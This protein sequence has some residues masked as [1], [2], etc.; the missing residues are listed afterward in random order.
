LVDGPR[1]NPNDIDLREEQL[2]IVKVFDQAGGRLL[3]VGEPGSGKTVLL[4]KIAEHLEQQHRKNASAPLPIVLNLSAWQQGSSVHSWM[5]DQLCD[6]VNGLGFPDPD[7][8]SDLIR[9]GRIAVLLDGLD[10]VPEAHRLDCLRAL[11]DFLPGVLD[12]VPV[13]VTCRIGEFRDLV[14]RDSPIGLLDAREATPLS[15]ADVRDNLRVLAKGNELTERQEA[16]QRIA[17]RVHR[18]EGRLLRSALTSPLIL[19]MAIEAPSLNPEQ[20]L[21]LKSVDEIR[22]QVCRSSVEDAFSSA[23]PRALAWLKFV[24]RNLVAS[25]NDSVTFRMESLTPDQAPPWLG[26]VGGLVLGLVFG[27]FGGLGF[28]LVGGLGFGLVVGLVCGL[29]FGLVFDLVSAIRSDEVIVQ[30]SDFDLPLKQS[31]QPYLISIA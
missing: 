19:T 16:W 20:L 24:A 9:S 6:R 23:P 13:V 22:S 10:E 3:L 17:N 8:A 29:V 15:F 7:L 18:T 2:D 14:D 11:N 5:I 21:K 28:G 30:A 1:S 4:Y 26:L 12:G 25:T 27:L 31:I